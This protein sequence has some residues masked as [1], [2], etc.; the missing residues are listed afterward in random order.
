[1]HAIPPLGMR[2]IQIETYRQPGDS[3]MVMFNLQLER[4]I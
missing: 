1:M 4:K 3:C 2:A